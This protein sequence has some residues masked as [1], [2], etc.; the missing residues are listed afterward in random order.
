MHQQITAKLSRLNYDTLQASINAI[1]DSLISFNN[2]PIGKWHLDIDAEN[3]EDKIIYYGETDI[4]I[5]KDETVEVYITLTTVGSGTGSIRIY[6]DW[7]NKWTDFYGNPVITPYDNPD[8]PNAVTQAKIIYDNAIYKM[9]YLNLYNSAKT[10]VW[11]AESNDGINWHNIQNTPVLLPGDS[12]SWDNYSVYAGAIIKEDNIFKMY[13]NGFQ[14]QY[15][16]WNIGLAVSSDGIHWEK[17]S[18]P[19]LVADDQLNQKIFCVEKT[20]STT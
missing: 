17:Y 16:K 4:N 7:G 15:G 2:V 3:S 9:W 6:V 14:D 8:F 20:L 11:Y 19:V 1:N 10:N 12:G 5:L 13:Y 18:E